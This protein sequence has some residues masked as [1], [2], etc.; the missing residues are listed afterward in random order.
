MARAPRLGKLARKPNE[1]GEDEINRAFD[2]L[3]SSPEFVQHRTD[4]RRR[5]EVIKRLVKV[6]RSTNRSQSDVAAT[7][8]TTQSAVSDLEGGL[9][10]P[11]LSTLQRYAR[12]VGAEVDVSVRSTH[13]EQIAEQFSRVTPLA[14]QYLL[15]QDDWQ[16][17]ERAKRIPLETRSVEVD[18]PTPERQT[19][20]LRLAS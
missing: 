8:G 20:I 17:V 4:A 7:M 15:L 14:L 18:Q 10:D 19:P 6:R 11:R 3:L 16:A 13:P 1:G 12:A 2:A 5:I 9:T